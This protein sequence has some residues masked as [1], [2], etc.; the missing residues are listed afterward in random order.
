MIKEN[1]S[2]QINEVILYDSIPYF[3]RFCLLL[4]ENSNNPKYDVNKT[5]YDMNW[6][7]LCYFNSLYYL[8]SSLKQK[9]K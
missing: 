3:K 6:I 9:F 4:L 5:K 7:F 1:Q 2:K 8:C